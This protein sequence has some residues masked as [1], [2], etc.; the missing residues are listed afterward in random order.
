[1]V[2]ILTCLDKLHYRC[3]VVLG[4]DSDNA[5]AIKDRFRGKD[6]TPFIDG[7]SYRYLLKPV[8]RHIW[9]RLA[10]G[11]RIILMKV[12]AHK[13]LP[14]NEAADKFVAKGHISVIFLGEDRELE[15]GRGLQFTK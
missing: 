10:Q 1:M 7:L 11:A 6:S 8:L 5:S 9:R 2:S 3:N 4:T 13:R 14:V 15:L 12:R